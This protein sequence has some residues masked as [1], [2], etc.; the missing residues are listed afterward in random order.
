MLLRC[1]GSGEDRIE[2][3]IDGATFDLQLRRQDDAVTEDWERVGLHVVWCGE[4][5]SGYE[6]GGTR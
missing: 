2:H 1:D 6:C 3:V 4:I 5:S